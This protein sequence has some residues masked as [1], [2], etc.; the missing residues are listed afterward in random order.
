M[1]LEQRKS[2]SN[3]IAKKKILICFSSNKLLDLHYNP[4]YYLIAKFVNAESFRLSQ[5]V[6][7]VNMI[8][9]FPFITPHNFKSDCYR[10]Y[11][12]II[13]P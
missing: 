2:V 12:Q 10:K 5:L 13:F 8:N 1:H 11:A 7:F 4:P 9:T 3:K 6:Y